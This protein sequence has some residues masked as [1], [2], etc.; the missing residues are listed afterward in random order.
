MSLARSLQKTDIATLN[1]WALLFN[2]IRQPSVFR[3]DTFRRYIASVLPATTF[4]ELQIPI[5]MN[6]VDLETGRQ[7][8]FGAGGRMDVPLHDAI[9]ASAALPL[10]YPPAEFGG[11]YYI[12]G[13]ILDPLPIERALERGAERVI[14]VDLSTELNQDAA[15][16][17]SKGLVGVHHRVL[18]VLRTHSRRQE[19]AKEWD[20]PVL[21][22]RPDLGSYGTWDFDKAGLFMEEGYRAA[23]AALGGEPEALS[24]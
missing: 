7:E 9:Y 14:A 22:I 8:W 2:G 3:D 13:G 11:R 5:S 23:V 6:A 19:M 16:E 10:Y 24:A 17:I 18:S 4:G 12:D 20:R 21:V 1:R 15:A